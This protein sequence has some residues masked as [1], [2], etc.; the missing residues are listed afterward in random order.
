MKFLSFALEIEEH[1]Q[2]LGIHRADPEA[3][4]KEFS[5]YLEKKKAHENKERKKSS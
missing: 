2:K 1:R 3:M 4:R 5:R